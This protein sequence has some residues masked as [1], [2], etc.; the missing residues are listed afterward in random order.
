MTSL[1]WLLLL[2]GGG[3]LLPSLYSQTG[4]Q[5]VLLAP[6]LLALGYGLSPAALG[7]VTT[8]AAADM[9]PALQMAVA[10][11]ALAAGLQVLETR[12]WRRHNGVLAKQLMTN[13]L[14]A[15]WSGLGVGAVLVIA[16]L[17]LTTSHTWR[18]PEILREPEV[19]GL[20]WGWGCLVAGTQRRMRP[21]DQ[22]FLGCLGLVLLCSFDGN[23]LGWTALLVVGCAGIV[24]LL[25]NPTTSTS[26]KDPAWPIRTAVLIGAT[27]LTCG[28]AAQLGLPG[29]LVGFFVGACLKRAGL[30]PAT[31]CRQVAASV[32]SVHVVTLV[33]VGLSLRVA[34]THI[35]WGIALGV[36][37]LCMRLVWEHSQHRV[38]GGGRRI[39][40]LVRE[41][42]AGRCI[43]LAASLLFVTHRS[44]LA[45]ALL[46]IMAIAVILSDIS[47]WSLRDF[48]P[49]RQKA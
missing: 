45:Q 25:G 20:L 1:L 22:V 9:Q 35:L 11:L 21:A 4:K 3:A 42:N 19:N 13:I 27:A 38:R 32:R 23:M 6:L 15:A 29:V 37:L 24:G 47:L 14:A 12:T 34:L 28:L 17:G 43:W 7:F 36:V 49:T 41:D 30:V 33:L 39:G 31:Q 16:Q 44:I 18:M 40:I 10:W 8:G 48:A 2:A 46:P 5:H 26:L